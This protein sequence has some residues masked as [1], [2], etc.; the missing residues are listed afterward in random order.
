M[1][2]YLL[3]VTHSAN[4]YR[5]RGLLLSD[6]KL[7]ASLILISLILTAIDSLGLLNIPKS[8]IQ[9][10]TSPIQYGLYKTA[11]STR[12]QFDFVFVARRTSQENKALSEQL[13]QVLSENAKLQKKLAETQGFL[14]QQKSLDP[15][16]YT[17]MPARPIGV[18]RYLFIDKGSADGLKLNQAVVYKDSY[19]GKIKELSPKKSQVMF[20][21]DPDSKLSA[22]SSNGA[23][24]KARGILTGR[25]GAEMLLDKILHQESIAVGDLVYSEGTEM[26]I[27]RGLVLGTVS[28]V[29]NQD[30]EI[31]KQAKIKP[32]FDISN[33]DIVFVITN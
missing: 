16:T 26:E 31:F 33:L 5:M 12:R 28:E 3:Q 14:E 22:F 1:T 17:M 25:F 18:S 4:I 32:V 11:T 13:A 9:T 20:L 21:T 29:I 8:L 15:Q 23:G 19:I 6:F 10:I 30:N 7:F 24:S 27:P 2:S